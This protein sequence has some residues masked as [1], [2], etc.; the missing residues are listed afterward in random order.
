MEVAAKVLPCIA[1]SVSSSGFNI[2][3]YKAGLLD[4]TDYF[5][6]RMTS[7]ILKTYVE[8]SR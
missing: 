4:G 2:E 7:Q 5:I 3:N 1:K 8:L 6:D